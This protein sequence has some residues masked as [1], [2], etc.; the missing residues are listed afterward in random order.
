MAQRRSL[1]RPTM[2][3]QRFRSPARVVNAKTIKKKLQNRPI[4]L[5]KLSRLPN[6]TICVKRR[7]GG[8]GDVLMTTPLLRA[9]KK[10]L[11]N[12]ILTYATDMSYSQGALAEIVKRNPF[13]DKVVPHGEIVDAVYDYC[14]DI[15]S[16]GLS[17]ERQ[18]TI[19][20]NRIDMFASAAGLS[21]IEDPVPT[22]MTTLEEQ[23]FARKELEEYSKPFKR[24]DVLFFVVQ[25][26]SNDARRSWPLTSV[27]AL[28]NLLSKNERHRVLL[29]D[30]GDTANFW[31]ENERLFVIKDRELKSSAPILE[32]SDLVV[33]PDSSFLHLAGAFSKKT[34]SIFGP[35]PPQSRINHYPNTIAVT[36]NMACSFCWYVSKCNR[37]TGNKLECLTKITPERVYEEVMRHLQEPYKTIQDP[38]YGRT[39][40]VHGQ[41][42][43][44][45]VK[46]SSRGLGDILM[47]ATGIEA[48]KRKY[49]AYQIHVA[50]PENLFSALENLPY[51]DQLV[52]IEKPINLK[53]YYM[54]LDISTPC[55]RYETARI[56]SGK[57]VE[58][59]R[60][61]IYA[62]ALGVRN[63]ITNLKPRYL[64][65]DEEKTEAKEFI[66]N[67]KLSS[68]KINL[69]FCLKAAEDY[70]SY[71]VDKI[72]ELIS[73]L[74]KKYNI[75]IFND[76]QKEIYENTIDCC[77]FPL[78]KAVAIMNECDYL[79]TVDTG[80]L[81]VAQAIDKPVI[82]LFGPIDYKARCRGYENVTIVKSDLPCVPCWRNGITVC[83][84]TGKIQ[85]F[86]KCLENISAKD[87]FQIIEQK[88]S[89]K[90]EQQ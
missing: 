40:T 27:Q 25:G 43:I 70:R 23:D 30:W 9:I 4:N 62:E 71:P 57:P 36:Y 48:L 87:I 6:P 7:L 78:R 33:C 10:H 31:T 83:K 12:C 50:V 80:L 58:K 54:I 67:L 17:E 65:S 66:A 29:F 59:N 37:H 2:I 82:A 5:E 53:R 61:E 19:P 20:P 46:R 11:P 73:L 49:P 35:I 56:S 72:K 41:D 75:F 64:I 68:K 79:I 88:F 74:K 86:S 84:E 51:I 1:Q 13:V 85:G 3:N 34:V 81:H 28:C 24:E 18:G 15:T 16:T 60:V 90:G 39:L 55:A 52:D 44:I 42:K 69:A 26:R 89:L 76:S 63:L 8:I 32:A 77:G 14:I 45:L 47:A 38:L 22:Y 21:V